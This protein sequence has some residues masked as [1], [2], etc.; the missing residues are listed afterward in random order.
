VE[1][2]SQNHRQLQDDDGPTHLPGI[3]TIATSWVGRKGQKQLVQSY[4]Q[5]LETVRVSEVQKELRILASVCYEAFEKL[6]ST[7]P[8]ATKAMILCRQYL[9]KARPSHDSSASTP[10]MELWKQTS[11]SG[12]T[13]PEDCVKLATTVLG[14]NIVSTITEEQKE[15]P[16]VW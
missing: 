5:S 10:L 6:Q 8:E 13:E 1:L 14:G 2:E 15:P 7:L 16:H 12:N 4:S 11:N 3:G 9:P